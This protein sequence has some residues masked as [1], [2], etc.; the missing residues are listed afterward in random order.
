MD[1]KYQKKISKIILINFRK[2][3]QQKKNYIVIF[4]KIIKICK[5]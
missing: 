3:Q 5:K 2:S 1:N 4:I